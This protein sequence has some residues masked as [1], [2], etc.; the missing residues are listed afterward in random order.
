LIQESFTA[1]KA[2]IFTFTPGPFKSTDALPADWGITPAANGCTMQ[3][4][5]FETN[6]ERLNATVININRHPAAY[7]QGNEGLIKN[8]GVDHLQMISDENAKIE[9]LLGLS[10]EMLSINDNSYFSRF[11]IV[12]TPDSRKKI[13]RLAS[14]VTQE[15]AEAHINQIDD[16]IKQPQLRVGLT[17]TA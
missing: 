7:H 9:K 6:F 10:G 13:F 16:F 17:Y 2:V 3:L 8:K 14:P 11:S 1:G 15:I 4:K 5:T 12:L